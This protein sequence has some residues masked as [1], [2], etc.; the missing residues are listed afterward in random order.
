M[1]RAIRAVH[2]EDLAVKRIEIARDGTISVITAPRPKLDLT[3][4]IESLGLDETRAHGA[5]P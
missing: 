4:E 1:R 2:K 5:A 3:N